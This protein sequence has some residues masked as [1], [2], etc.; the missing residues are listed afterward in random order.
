M[1]NYMKIAIKQAKK[2]IKKNHGGPF[3]CVIVKDEK[4]IAKG[5]NEV[6]KN[7]DATCH[8]EMTAI[9]KASKKLKTHDLSGCEL[10]TTGEPCPMCLCACLWANIN[11]VYYG[12]TINDNKLIGF[13]DEEF[14]K[15]LSDRKNLK[16]YLNETN[17]EECLEL[18]REYNST[19]NQKY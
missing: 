16:D 2:G 3:G 18:F 6:L 19:E 5:H 11:K 8:G 10:Y 13:R 7:H 14:D 15:M 1:A 9:R 12:C 17:R 4:I